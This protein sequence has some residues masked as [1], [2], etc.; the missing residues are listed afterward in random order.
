MPYYT[1]PMIAASVK[2]ENADCLV[3]ADSLEEAVELASNGIFEEIYW[4]EVIDS[5]VTK[6]EVNEDI[7]MT[8]PE[9]Y[10]DGDPS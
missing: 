2:W 8:R 4:G 6:F 1:V 3:K 5:E 10:T 9:E 7:D